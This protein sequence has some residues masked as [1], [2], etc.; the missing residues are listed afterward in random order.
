MSSRV[1]RVIAEPDTQLSHDSLLMTVLVG[2][3]EFFLASEKGL[4]AWEK[5]EIDVVEDNGI[6]LVVPF[7]Q[8]EQVAHVCGSAKRSRPLSFPESSSSHQ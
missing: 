3:T 6:G 7:V 4:P 1:I 2:D 5:L 8:V